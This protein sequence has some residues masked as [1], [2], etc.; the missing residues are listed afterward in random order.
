MTHRTNNPLGYSPGDYIALLRSLGCAL[1][2]LTGGMYDCIQD[3]WADLD[4][5]R[6]AVPVGVVG[7]ST[8]YWKPKVI[9]REPEVQFTLADLGCVV[10]TH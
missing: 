9:Y 7:D 1:L 5:M 4:M 10:W 6:D 2:P 3:R 8:L